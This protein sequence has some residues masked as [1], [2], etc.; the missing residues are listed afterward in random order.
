MSEFRLLLL[1]LHFGPISARAQLLLETLGFRTLGFE[2]CHLGG[3]RLSRIG[4]SL[5]GRRSRGLFLGGGLNVG[6]FSTTTN[7]LAGGRSGSRFRNRSGGGGRGAA[8]TSRRRGRCFLL[9]A[10]ALFAFPPR[11]S[12]S[13]LIIREQAYMAAKWNVQLTK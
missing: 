6:S 12:A 13:H 5:R 4:G 9:G 8:T 11:A 3:G 7:R 1:G 10:R 2:A